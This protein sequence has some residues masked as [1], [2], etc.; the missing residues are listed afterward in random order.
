M[1]YLSLVT[2]LFTALLVGG[3]TFLP[4]AP[5]TFNDRF[6]YNT[7]FDLGTAPVPHLENVQ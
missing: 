2:V 4:E 1:K 6:H 5:V 7:A 3:A